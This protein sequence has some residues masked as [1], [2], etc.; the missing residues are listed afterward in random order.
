MSKRR[1]RIPWYVHELP[2]VVPAW[3]IPSCWRTPQAR[4]YVN[5]YDAKDDTLDALV[6]NCAVKASLPAPT[7]GRVL[8]HVG[9]THVDTSLTPRSFLR[10]EFSR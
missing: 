3:A 5:A 2:V 8:R 7:R 1:R 9:Y 6:E 4:T 10:C